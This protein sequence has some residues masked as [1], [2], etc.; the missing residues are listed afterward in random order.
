MNF[1]MVEGQR[2]IFDHVNLER[3]ELYAA[4]LEA[5]C[6]FDCDLSGAD[7]SQATRYREPVFTAPFS[8]KLGA[9]NTF[10]TS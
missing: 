1:R 7:V 4:H 5:A 10:E 8:R 3:G 2:V 6:F 9:A